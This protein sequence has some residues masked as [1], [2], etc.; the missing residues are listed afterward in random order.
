MYTWK[1]FEFNELTP[2]QLYAI[3]QLRERVFTIE[4]H[5]NEPDMDDVDITALHFT[6]WN[7]NQLIGYLRAYHA[8]EKIKIGRVVIHLDYQ[9]KG[10]GR[11]LMIRAV[12]QLQQQFSGK[13]IAMSAQQ[14][15]EKFYQSLGFVTVSD[16]YMEAGI[17]HVGMSLQ[18][19]DIQ[20]NSK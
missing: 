13:I 14:Y 12:A 3:L 10:L 17:Q 19:L 20:E 16:M 7:E 8:D 4:Q 18:P 1:W 15:L 11:E 6:A 5:C 2:R 9:G